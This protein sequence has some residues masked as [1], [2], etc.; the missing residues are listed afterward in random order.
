ME[1]AASGL[2][3]SAGPAGFATLSSVTFSFYPGLITRE[4]QLSVSVDCRVDFGSFT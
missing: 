4:V 3:G 1:I 2:A